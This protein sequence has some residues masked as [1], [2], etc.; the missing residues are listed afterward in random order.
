MFAG[1]GPDYGSRK[2]SRRGPKPKDVGIADE[3][4]RIVLTVADRGG[5]EGLR[6][7]QRGG[8]AYLDGR[9]AG[10]SANGGLP[11]V[12]QPPGWPHTRPTLSVNV[13]DEVAG[14]WQTALH[15]AAQKN[16]TVVAEALLSVGAAVDPET[17][18][19]AAGALLFRESAALP[20]PTLHPRS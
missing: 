14:T 9:V 20:S 17:A 15:V 1:A 8:C 11:H 16:D 6:Q 7:L 13:R 5:T 3:R 12:L 18:R 10:A 4:V 19:C 2:R